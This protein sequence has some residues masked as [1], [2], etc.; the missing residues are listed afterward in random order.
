MTRLDSQYGNQFAKHH[1]ALDCTIFSYQYDQLKILLSHRRFEPRQGE[2]SLL[3]GWLREEETV[4]EAA[5]RVLYQITGLQDIF[6]EQVQVFSQPDRDPGGRVISAIFFAMIPLEN[7]NK[8]LAREHGAKWWPFEQMPKL[9][10][11]HDKMVEFAHERL[12]QKASYELVGEDLLPARFT[13]LQLR[14]LYEAIF[15]RKFDPGNFRKKVLSL[16]V[17]ERLNEKNTND[18]RRGAYYYRFKK[19]KGELMPERI[20]KL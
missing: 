14:Q 16:K 4:E 10:F 5:A 11:D 9:I 2:W 3:G 13:I 18:S 12:K 1:V 17:L 19:R 7:H 8:E 20:V 6:L 15:Q